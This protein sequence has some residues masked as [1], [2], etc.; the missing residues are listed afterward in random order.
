MFRFLLSAALATSWLATAW[1]TTPQQQPPQKSTRRNFFQ[2]QLAIIAA[3]TTVATTSSSSPAFAGDAVSLFLEELSASQE[4]VKTLPGLLKDQEWDKVRT[5]LKTPPVNKLWNLGDS[6]N[7]VMKLAKETGNVELFELKD[8]L[9]Y[10]L[11]MC[12]QLTYDNVFVYFQPGSGKINIKEP[13]EFAE[14][15]ARQIAEAIEESK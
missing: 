13:V 7:T 14:K 5:I 10:S 1:T 8:D 9:A 12:D 11:Q 2:Q 4:K 3:T 15:A 6:Q